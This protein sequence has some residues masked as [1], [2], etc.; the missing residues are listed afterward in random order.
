MRSLLQ[1]QE[2]LGGLVPP[3][4]PASTEDLLNAPGMGISTPPHHTEL[5]QLELPA[6]ENMGYHHVCNMIQF[7]NSYLI[8]F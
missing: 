6:M 4:T 5:E 1:E 8:P 2:S 3:M 7:T